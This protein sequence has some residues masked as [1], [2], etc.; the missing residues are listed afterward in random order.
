MK[1]FLKNNKQKEICHHCKHEYMKSDSCNKCYAEFFI[2]DFL[3]KWH[4]Q[5]DFKDIA[6]YKGINLGEVSSY[7]LRPIL[8]LALRKLIEDET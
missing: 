7:D 1:D 5:D 2:T 8:V 3:E 4:M 6:T